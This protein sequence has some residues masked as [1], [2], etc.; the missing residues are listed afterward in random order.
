MEKESQTPPEPPRNPF[1][2][3]AAQS[4]RPDSYGSQTFNTPPE[5]TRQPV[6]RQF[7]SYRL[8]GTYERSWLSDKRL[9]RTRVGNFI[10]WAF[11]VVG[12]GLSAFVNYTV[13]GKVNRRD[14]CL[15]LDDQFSSF[16]TDTWNRE[17]QVS[18]IFFFRSSLHRNI[19]SIISGWRIRHRVF[20][21]D[22]NRR[23]K[24]VCRRGRSSYRPNI[25]D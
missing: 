6:R 9:K 3:S 13:L 14:Y 20:R 22:Y 21:L 4:L 12:L 8:H 2:D 24:R 18:C 5:G 11:V 1:S 16:D 15:I 7:K 17:V 10:I 25:D 19:L 23:S